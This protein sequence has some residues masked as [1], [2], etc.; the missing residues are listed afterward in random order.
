MWRGTSKAAGLQTT[1]RRSLW[2]SSRWPATSPLDSCTCINTTSHT[3]RQIFQLSGSRPR[4][5]NVSVKSTLSFC[6][7]LPETISWCCPSVPYR[8]QHQWFCCRR[9]SSICSPFHTYFHVCLFLW[10]IRSATSLSSLYPP[11]STVTWHWETAC[12]LLTSQWRSEIMGFQ[13]SSTR[14]VV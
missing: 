1:W 9:W 5:L 3:G 13:A 2:F 7:S 6:W 12:C 10:I 8:L 14:S 11:F 4:F